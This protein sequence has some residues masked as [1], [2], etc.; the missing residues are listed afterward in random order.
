MGRKSSIRSHNPNSTVAK[1]RVVEA[2]V[3][4][5]HEDPGVK[6]ER[7][8]RVS[9]MGFKGRKREIDVLLTRDVAGYPVRLAI[10]CKNEST[11]IGAKEIDAF[12]GKLQYV[13][14]P[15]Q[16]GIFVSA[17]GYTVQAKE[18]AAHG[19]LR[20]LALN[21]VQRTLPD[22]VATALQTILFLM[23]AVTQIRFENAVDR[24]VTESETYS[25][26]DESG[27]P[28]G[29]VEDLIWE[30]WLRGRLPQG[31]GAHKLTLTIPPGWYQLVNG[32]LQHIVSLA[33]SLQVVG[34]L[35]TMTGATSEHQ[36]I[37]TANGDVERSQLSASFPPQDKYPVTRVL[38]EAELAVSTAQRG[39]VTIRIG[40]IPAPRIQFR[41]V[42]WPPSERA[43]I[44]L[45]E[46]LNAIESGQIPASQPF[47]AFAAEGHDVSVLF[48][49]TW[50]EEWLPVNSAAAGDT[51]A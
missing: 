12:I 8:V 20:L 34:H 9:P 46:H 38:S 28:C 16:H 2:I 30:Q 36:L 31:I 21:Q 5:M 18:R 25:F 15:V 49:R 7:N 44:A 45:Q 26:V 19:G 39:I 13:G 50:E 23:L 43:R 4:S 3:A 6:V 24:P 51:T 33:A 42:L 10:E 14:I 37:N 1:G 41:H 47:D 29:S 17:S 40:R 32:K 35:V 48:E 27:E 11:P 22:S